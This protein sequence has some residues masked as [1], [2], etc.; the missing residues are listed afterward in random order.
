MKRTR[1]NFNKQQQIAVKARVIL[2]EKEKLNVAKTL[3]AAMYRNKHISR[4]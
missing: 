2:H 1:R 4:N 3:I